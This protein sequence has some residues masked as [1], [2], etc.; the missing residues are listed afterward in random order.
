MRLPSKRIRKVVELLLTGECRTQKAACERVGLHPDHVCR[1]LKKPR[2]Q[3]FIAHETRRAIAN[4]QM[5]AAAT[6]VKLLGADSERVQSEVAAKLLAIAGIKPDDTSRVAVSLDIRAGY[7]IDI[8]GDSPA[9]VAAPSQAESDMVDVTPDTP[10]LEQ[11]ASFTPDARW[12]SSATPGPT[13]EP[14]PRPPPDA[15]D[16]ALER[17]RRLRG[18]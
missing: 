17:R 5:P 2:L 9:S 6:L 14:E 15:F 16:L 1:E 13:D 8:T 12:S 4:A 3:A 11:P 7:V 10:R 18:E